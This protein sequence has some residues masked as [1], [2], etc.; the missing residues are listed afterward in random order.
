V[1][2]ILTRWANRGLRID[3]SIRRTLRPAFA[4]DV[5]RATQRVVLPSPDNVEVIWTTFLLPS[6]ESLRISLRRRSME[7]LKGDDG[8]ILG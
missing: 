6:P 3:P 4:A 8:M 1:F 2:S 7:E 5:A